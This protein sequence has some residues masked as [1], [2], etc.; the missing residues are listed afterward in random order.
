MRCDLR[1]YRECACP[2]GTCQQ[3]RKAI[4]APVIHP[5]NRDMLAL[6]GCAVVVFLSFA[7]VGAPEMERAAKVNQEQITW[8][9]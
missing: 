5:T 9:K 2:V 3:Q 7:L 8:R 1:T 6:F 4:P